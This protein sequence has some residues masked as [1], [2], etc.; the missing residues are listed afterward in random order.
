MILITH[1]DDQSPVVFSHSVFVSHI[2]CKAERIVILDMVDDDDDTLNTQFCVQ[3]FQCHVHLVYR[4]LCQHMIWVRHILVGIL[5]MR[6]GDVLR[7]PIPLLS[8][9]A[10]S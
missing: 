5:Q 7:I 1:N 8:T 9:A 4:V 3:T 10:D 6:Y 2:L